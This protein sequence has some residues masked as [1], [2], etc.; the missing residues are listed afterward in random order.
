[1]ELLDFLLVCGKPTFIKERI[2]CDWIKEMS[3]KTE[4]QKVRPKDQRRKAKDTK[5][6]AIS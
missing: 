2:H 5:Q 6:G 3:T 1:M 4:T